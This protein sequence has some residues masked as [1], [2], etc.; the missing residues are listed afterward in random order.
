L[1]NSSHNTLRCQVTTITSLSD[2]RDKTNIVD[3]PAGLSFVEALRPV[4]FDWNMRDGA[5]SGVTE[6]GFIAQELQAAQTDTGVTVPNLVYDDNPER[7]EAS[8]STLIPVLV[9]AIQELKAE[10]D[11]LKQQLNNGV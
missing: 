9:K 10:V 2:A 7:L 6:F 8:P 4:S 11:S 5:K 3:I 1:G